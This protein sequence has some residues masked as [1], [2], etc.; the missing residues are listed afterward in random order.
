MSSRLW[1]SLAALVGFAGSAIFSSW[2]HWERNWF[3]LGY[4]ALAG[5]FLVAFARAG[6]IRPALQVRRHW[7]AGVVGGVLVG[8]VLAH[9]VQAQPASPRPTGIALAG[10]LAWLGVVYG[11]LDALLLT[12]V[13][14]ISV[15]GSRPLEVLRR[16]AA[17]ARWGVL[18]LLASL[19]V[20]STYHVGFAEFRGPSLVQPLVGNAMVTAGYLL[21]GSPLAAV[22]AHVIMHGAAVVH[23]MEGTAQ[24]PPHY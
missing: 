8:L 2:L 10:A 19:I 6:Q 22:L 5:P 9:G 21:T 15:Y 4:A 13:P 17:R 3:V 7:R 14:V 24:L 20:T 16:G 11:A 1:V 23:G 18:A 12:V